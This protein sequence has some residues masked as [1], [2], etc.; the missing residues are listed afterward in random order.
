MSRARRS[1]SIVAAICLVAVTSLLVAIGPSATATETRYYFHS[2]ATTI[3]NIDKFFANAAT[4]NTTPPEFT[5]PVVAVDLPAGNGSAKALYDPA[6]EGSLS[7]SISSLSLDFWEKAPVGDTLGQVDYSA[8]VWVGT[9]QYALPAFSRIVTESPDQPV[10]VK[11]TFTT[12][13]AA[14]GET[15]LPLA[16]PAS[17]PA[18]VNISGVYAVDEAAATILYD[19]LDYPSGFSITTGVTASPSPSPSGTSPSPTPT[20]T[21]TAPPPDPSVPAYQNF[22]P[23]SNLGQDAGEPSIGINPKT[24]NVMY[25]AGTQTLRINNFDETSG[26]ADW[27]DVS[28]LM[29]QLDTWDPILFTDPYTGR[30]I[31]SQL[32]FGDDCSWIAATDNDGNDWT[33]NPHG[34]GI[35]AG[36]DHQTVGGGPFSDQGPIKGGI[37]YKDATYYCSHQNV[38]AFCALSLDGGIT[39]GPGVPIYSLL[40]CGGLHGHVKVGP[41]GTVYVP[42]GSC[43][44]ADGNDAQGLAV[45]RDNGQTWSM[46]FI[47]NSGS[48]IESDSAVG[49]GAGNT[50]YYGYEGGDGHAY[51]TVSR[52][53]GGDWGPSIDLGASLGIKNAQ[54]PAVVA[55]DDDRAAVAF[56]GT[57]TGGN[58]QANNFSGVWHLY[59]S[60][61]YDGGDH[62]TTVDATPTDPVQKSCIYMGGFGATTPACRNLLD[63]MDIGVDKQG[64]V[65]VGYADGCVDACVTGGANTFARE[66]VLARQSSGKGLYSAY[67][68][69]L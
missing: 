14:D 50:V 28:S 22:S 16:I 18:T 52:N 17:G 6:W 61:T 7:G 23:P 48:Q 40:D 20:G 10:N 32:E 5:D 25:I 3:N 31:V 63:F 11:H 41:D 66:A 47:P 64:R 8:S 24:G 51:A 45:S 60:T 9:T 21:S 26:T 46:S 4:F 19:S 1:T 65:Y 37:G 55:G 68:G 67:D 29:T 57:T 2:E 13:L 34:C 12:M 49:I 39:F 15:E 53:H 54:F 44:D 43:F 36:T 58:D 59:V 62:W 38:T 56:L 42:N 33:W 27:Q 35:P 30:T 69:Q